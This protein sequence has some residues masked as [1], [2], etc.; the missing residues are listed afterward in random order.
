MMRRDSSSQ[1]D[2]RAG[3]PAE[4]H[5][6]AQFI[7]YPVVA[8]QGARKDRAGLMLAASVALFLGAVTFFTLAGNRLAAPVV[9]EAIATAPSLPVAAPVAPVVAPMP[10]AVAPASG[11]AAA[12]PVAGAANAR[13]D[14][15][16]IQ[17]AIESRL[18]APAVIYQAMADSGVGGVS[19]PATGQF[20]AKPQP[21][22]LTAEEQFAR[23]VSGENDS[24]AA[25]PMNAPAATIVQGTLIPGVLETAV[26]TDLAG[27]VRAV[28]SRDIKS[29]DGRQVLIPRGSRVIGQ[30]QSGLAVGQTRVYILWTRLIRPDGVSIAL[31]SPSVDSSG[32]IGLGGKVNSHFGKRFGS[33]LLLSTIGAV[34]Q[35]IGGGGT[36]VILA[37]PQAV[38]SSSV[39]ASINIPPT[40]Q[41]KQGQ[42]IMIFVARDLDFSAVTPMTAY[43]K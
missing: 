14:P 28:I 35:A 24:T 21:Q 30:Y 42:P 8:G 11:A 27:F 26:N 31:N 18:R 32:Q 6:D 3:A 10:A 40:V 2:P 16:A 9:R 38:V 23:R 36:S 12:L 29:Y 20:P 43:A 13:L 4:D 7:G 1:T 22:D 17:A 15:A 33:A 34:G 37:G 5:D 41:V 19:A 39:N 25:M